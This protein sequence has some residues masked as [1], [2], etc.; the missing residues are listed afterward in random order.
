MALIGFIGVGN[1]GYPM[2]RGAMEQFSKEEILF[3]TKTLQHMKEIE[4]E[5]GFSWKKLFKI[6]QLNGILN[7]IQ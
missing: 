2:L 4:E 1:M 5:K 6:I 7:E 3:T